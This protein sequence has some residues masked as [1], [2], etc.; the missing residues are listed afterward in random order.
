MTN[1]DRV[2]AYCAE[3]TKGTRANM[4]FIAQSRTD[5]PVLA[6]GVRA[7]LALHRPETCDDP[8]H[9]EHPMCRECGPGWTYPCATV[10][11]LIDQGIEVPHV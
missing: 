5:L 7:V 11:A 2:L 8:G 3:A 9:G 1:A 4:A 6:A 10:Q